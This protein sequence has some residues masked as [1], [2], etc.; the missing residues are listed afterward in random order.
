MESCGMMAQKTQRPSSTKVQKR[1]WFLICQAWPRFKVTP[2]G[3]WSTNLAQQFPFQSSSNYL[4]LRKLCFAN[5]FCDE[6]DLIFPVVLVVHVFR[7]LI[8]ESQ[9]L[10]PPG[11]TSVWPH[12]WNERSPGAANSP[13]RIPATAVRPKKKGGLKNGT[14]VEHAAT[15]KIMIHIV[16]G[17]CGLR[18]SRHSQSWIRIDV[19]SNIYIYIYIYYL[20]KVFKSRISHAFDLLTLAGC[21]RRDRPAGRGLLAIG[22]YTLTGTS[23]P[24]LF[25]DNF[26]L[27]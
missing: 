11:H 25:S 10:S 26:G 9:L 18:V 21:L 8:R 20:Y 22:A 13:A 5:L 4:Q 1:P 24:T 12:P 7:Q 16:L 6:S 2:A 19:F 14:M 17:I 23:S 15:L 27:G 3:L